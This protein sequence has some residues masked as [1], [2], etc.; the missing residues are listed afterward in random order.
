MWSLTVAV[1]GR[2]SRLFS[3][4]E[5]RGMPA[6]SLQLDLWTHGLHAIDLPL[7]NHSVDSS[8]QI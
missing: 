1:Y 4:G 6:A 5:H 2:G 7:R 8:N 3:P